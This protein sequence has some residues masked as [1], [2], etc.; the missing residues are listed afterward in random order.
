MLTGVLQRSAERSTGA[1]YAMSQ[2]CT[3]PEGISSAG[4]HGPPAADT[5]N[6]KSAATKN[7]GSAVPQLRGQ[8]ARN[9][10]STNSTN[11]NLAAFSRY[12]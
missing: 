5:E 11:H 9:V 7:L 4:V 8:S 2:Y 6:T 3:V 12:Y 10:N 1:A